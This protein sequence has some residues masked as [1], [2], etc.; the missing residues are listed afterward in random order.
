MPQQIEAVLRAMWVQLNIREVLQMFCT[1]SVCL[2][3]T[4]FQI[5]DRLRD[6]DWRQFTAQMKRQTNLL[7]EH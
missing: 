7:G 6:V 2:I 5:S 4:Y 3:A 1:V